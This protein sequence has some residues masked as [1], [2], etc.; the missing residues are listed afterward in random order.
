M[1]IEE[2]WG[3]VVSLLSLLPLMMKKKLSQETREKQKIES[4][5]KRK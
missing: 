2:Y 4:W 1:M 3:E 5:K